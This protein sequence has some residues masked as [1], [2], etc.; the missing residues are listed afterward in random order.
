MSPEELIMWSL[1]DN[2][3]LLILSIYGL[4]YVVATGLS[5]HAQTQAHP[6]SNDHP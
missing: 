4:L 3:W 1:H 5:V 6:P 2:H